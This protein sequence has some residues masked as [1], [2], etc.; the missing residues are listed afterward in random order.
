MVRSFF[1]PRQQDDAL[2]ES[3]QR[4]AF[5]LGDR[6]TDFDP[7]L[8]LVGDARYVLIGEA[9]H[10]SH[11]FYR[12]R[13]EITKRLIEEKG[14]TAV[15]VEADWPDA[16]RVNR[17]VRGVSDDPDASTALD[18]FKRFPTW[19][20]RNRDVIEFVNWLKAYNS[21]LEEGATA[22]GFYGLDIYSLYQ[23]IEVILNY[24]D[25]VDPEAAARAR[26]RYSCFD[27]NGERNS[28]YYG[29]S[30]HFGL[31]SDCEEE[32]VQQLIELR[33]QG[34]DYARGDG[35]IP[36]DEF[37]FIEQNAR[38]VKNA[39]EYYRTMF[40][41]HVASW[42]LRDRHMGE[43]LDEL[44]KHLDRYSRKTKVVVWAHNS[45]LGDARG[46]QLSAA[47]EWNVGQLVRERHP[48]ENVLIGFTT[49][50]GTVTA[51]SNWGAIAERKPIR[52]PLDESYE[53]LFARVE[54][55]NFGLILRG[56]PEVAS[57]LRQPRLQRAIGV[58]YRPL[59]ERASHYFEARL[60]DQFDAV[61]HFRR[62]QAVEP[63]ERT[64][65]WETGEAPETYPFNV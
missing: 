38:L 12:T 22:C 53:Q 49:A 1:A 35:S 50:T 28:Q 55:P 57:P 43:T 64:P 16:Y 33:Q 44:V 27:S 51:A 14:F 31:R 18:D 23:S 54:P 24:L 10:G 32:V 58:I 63:L 21:S 19:M 20:W 48:K 6:P 36:E 39:E 4:S 61:L 37:F 42:N 34:A 56:N 41:G 15:A 17:Y 8:D 59:T 3:I 7:I 47:G 40:R 62:S 13:A 9:S 25:R 30:T 26:K 29:Y 52:Q 11:E 45:H 2:V 60:S 65:Q 5:E 46:T